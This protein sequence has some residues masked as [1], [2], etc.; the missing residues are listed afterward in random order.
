[1]LSFQP[2][3]RKLPA[4]RLTIRRIQSGIPHITSSCGKYSISLCVV[5]ALIRKPG[6]VKRDDEKLHVR[7][8]DSDAWW[9][10]NA[11]RTF[12]QFLV[13]D[14]F[15]GEAEVD[16]AELMQPGVHKREVTLKMD[17]DNRK[18]KTTVIFTAEFM[19]FEGLP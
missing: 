11:E 7:L 15:L 12:R 10:D 4:G 5:H 3:G 19:K 1:M 14:D 16:M 13:R 17:G 6:C 8:Y 2:V 18:I 9:G